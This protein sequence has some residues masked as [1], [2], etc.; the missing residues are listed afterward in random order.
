MNTHIEK[1]YQQN[2][3]YVTNIA[4]ELWKCPETAMHEIS[5]CKTVADF[6]RS[7]DFQVKTLP[8]KEGLEGPNAIVAT[9]GE[10]KPKIGILGEYDALDGLGQ[11]AVPYYSPKSSAGHGC[12]HN[13]MAA[14]CS[15]AAVAIRY[16]MEKEKL[17]GSIVFFGCPA[18]ETIEGKP[19][20]IKDG[21]FDDIDICLGWHPS[22]EA[23]HVS[24]KILLAN[25]NMLF[26]FKGKTAH[27][28][29]NP[30]MG[31]SALDA[32]ELMNVGVNYLREHVP[33][34]VR[35]HYVYT[36]AGEKPNIVPDFAQ[37]HYFIRARSR[38]T[39][40]EV[41]DRVEKVAQGAA[42]MTETNVSWQINAACCATKV[43]HTLNKFLYDAAAKIP[44]V[45]YSDDDIDFAKE[46][47]KNVTGTDATHDLLPTSLS[48]L[49]GNEIFMSESTDLSDVS[50][51]IPTA[52]IMGLG[53]V[54]GL[55]GHHWSVVAAGGSSIGHVGCLQA[56]K[57]IAQCGYDLLMNP[58]MI[59][60]AWKDHKSNS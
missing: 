15:S 8:V 19:L 16:V 46:L 55:P 36:H 49:T 48:P 5:S 27:A 10:G 58:N 47:Y 50:Q 17:P 28:A 39:A 51:I 53:M 44:P 57:V 13:L 59:E 45:V 18:E 34:G 9:Y 12:G 4:E 2:S 60:M 21:L 42:T 54:N 43:N 14:A 37:L 35:M 24:E 20:M 26:T 40:D 22:G 52:W 38:K 30:H 11:E 7:W 6:L 25:T 1:W 29:G 23:L 31:R 3:K 33:D 56:G 32:A 41:V